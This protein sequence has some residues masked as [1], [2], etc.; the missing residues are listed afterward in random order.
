M[1]KHIY[2]NNKEHSYVKITYFIVISYTSK[3]DKNRKEIPIIDEE[4]E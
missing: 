1:A 2:I 3:Y 4:M